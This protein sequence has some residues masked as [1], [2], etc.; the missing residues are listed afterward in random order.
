MMFMISVMA[1]SARPTAKM[2]WY[3]M[4]PCASLARGRLRDV[5]RHGLHAAQRV[6]RQVGVAPAA[7]V[8]IIVSPMARDMAR[9]KLAMMPDSAAGTTVRVAT[10]YFVAPSAYA[11]SRS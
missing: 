2:V 4:E 1:N 5:G 6:Q 7:M 9:M 11:P 3:S 8:T 10:S